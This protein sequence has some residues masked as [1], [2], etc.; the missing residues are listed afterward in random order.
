MSGGWTTGSRPNAIAP[1]CTRPCIP[2][3]SPAGWPAGSHRPSEAS[4]ICRSSTSTSTFTDPEL[5]QFLNRMLEAERAGAK[6]L[7]V[8]L[9]EWPRH[10]TEWAMLRK[11]HEDEAHNCAL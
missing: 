8:F 9:D 10:G 5:D 3:S 2:G 1:T 4:T 7:I 6:A 11:I